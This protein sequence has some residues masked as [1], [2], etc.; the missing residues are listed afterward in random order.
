MN[1]QVQGRGGPLASTLT[2]SGTSDY[3]Y[4]DPG[5]GQFIE[6]DPGTAVVIPKDGAFHDSRRNQFI[7][8]K[9]T[10]FRGFTFQ[11]GLNVS[12]VSAGSS[13]D[14]THIL[15]ETSGTPSDKVFVSNTTGGERRMWNFSDAENVAAGDNRKIFSL[16]VRRNDGADVDS[17]TVELGMS[18]A[19]PLGADIGSAEGTRYVKIR[20]D[21]W[22]LVWKDVGESASA[23]IYYWANWKDGVTAQYECP[24][25]EGQDGTITVGAGG[26]QVDILEPTAHIVTELADTVGRTRT[27]FNLVLDELYRIPP[28]GWMGCTVVPRSNYAD[29]AS[30]GDGVPSAA[31][32]LAWEVSATS[33]IRWRMSNSTGG[34]AFQINTNGEG[35]S[36]VFTALDPGDHVVGEPM[37]LVASWGYRLGSF[38]CL[39]CLNGQVVALDTASPNGMPV[40]SGEIAIGR[41]V[42]SPGTS[43]AQCLVQQ[44]GIGNRALSRADVRTLS[45]WFQTQGKRTMGANAI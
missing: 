36:Q 3:T 32:I 12:L 16:L 9:P 2:Y 18:T 44:V 30:T 6:A 26:S 21:G 27:T 15:R 28:A 11:A 29:H 43:P 41:G 7:S 22:F 4:W 8:S 1:A 10:S 31:T 24:Q 40:G 34:V 23:S 45:R 17:S 13:P 25:I 35:A 5:Q 33:R 19:D 14:R 39:T 38:Y 42:N 37:G 20:S